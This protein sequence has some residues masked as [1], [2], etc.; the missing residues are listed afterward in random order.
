MGKRLWLVGA[1]VGCCCALAAPGAAAAAAFTPASGSPFSTG[2]DPLSVASSADGSLLAVA[3]TGD[4]S[5]S[6]YAVSS[7]GTLT[8]LAGSPYPTGHAPMAV[9]FDPDAPILAVANANDKSV[10]TFVD[11][12]GEMVQTGSAGTGSSSG[13]ESLSFDGAGNVLAAGDGD[14]T[15]A[16]FDIGTDGAITAVSGSPFPVTMSLPDSVALSPDGTT[17]AAGDSANGHVNLYSVSAATGVGAPLSVSPLSLGGSGDW[18]NVAFSPDGALLAAADRNNNALSVFTTSGGSY[19]AVS[20]SPLSIDAP[21][22]PVFSPNSALLAVPQSGGSVSVFGSGGLTAISGS[23]F[24]INAL[25]PISGAAFAAGGGV[26]AAL[27]EDEDQVAT[28]S[29]GPPTAVIATPANGATYTVGQS[30]TTSF[31]CTEATDGPGIASCT[32]TGGAS[33]TGGTLNTSSAGQHTYTVTATSDDGQ[34]ATTSVTYTVTSPPPVTPAAP[35]VTIT[36]PASG[37]TYTLGQTVTAAFSCADGSGGPGITSC[38]GTDANGAQVSTA[39]SGTQTFKVT[40]TS[41]DG[42]TTTQTVTYTVA[43]AAAPTKNAITLQ[44]GS[45]NPVVVIGKKLSWG[46][47]AGSGAP[48]IGTGSSRGS[49]GTL[50]VTIDPKINDISALKTDYTS[51]HQYSTATLTMTNAD[52]GTTV[53]IMLTGVLIS[54]ISIT[55]EGDTLQ[56]QVTFIYTKA[57]ES[58]TTAKTTVTLPKTVAKKTSKRTVS[59]TGTIVHLIPAAQS[60]VIAE[61]DGE[62]VAIHSTNTQIAVGKIVTAKTTPLIDGTY[63]ATK[64]TFTGHANVALLKGTVTFVSTRGH[65]YVIS[66]SG[67]SIG[68]YRLARNA[69]PPGLGTTVTALVAIENRALIQRSVRALKKNPGLICV[70]GQ[71]VGLTTV[72]VDGQPQLELEITTTDSSSQS[73]LTPTSDERFPVSQQQSQTL[74]DAVSTSTTDTQ[75]LKLCGRGEKETTVDGQQDGAW[76]R[77]KNIYSDSSSP[78]QI[79]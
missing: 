78:V 41:G 71:F 34:T 63:K 20:G 43:P 69:T 57:T 44:L 22:K 72:T 18:I 67:T 9:A 45:S 47:G 30:V 58:L 24:A 59:F 29:V 35:T 10:E 52:G 48:P 36:S 19:G 21:G 33:G 65:Y 76:N 46:S 66:G 68:L 17:L 75:V 4:N 62:L 12:S 55:G 14:S 42:Q 53:T 77:V 28:L 40:A 3:N 5:V 27:A 51:A 23:P 6:V 54:E 64:L 11:V 37:A 32:G 49:S 8:P 61:S 13:P 38:A 1:V 26:L 56:E 73:T 2:D 79:S 70:E 31:K 60:F 74:A 7:T 16:L 39:E 50:T 15:V 25:T